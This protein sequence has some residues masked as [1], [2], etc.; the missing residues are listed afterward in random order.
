MRDESGGIVMQS[1]NTQQLRIVDISATVEPPNHTIG[2]DE[3]GTRVKNETM[4]WPIET[5]DSAI[6][7]SIYQILKFKSHLRTHV[8]SPSHM[9]R[10]AKALSDFPASTWLGR[11][12]FF[13]FQVSE[14]T[15]ITRKMLTEADNGRLRKGDIVVAHST[16]KFLP[17]D[18]VN[19]NRPKLSNAAT[20]YLLEKQVKMYGWDNSMGFE[21]DRSSGSDI[22][23][24][25]TLLKNDV[26]L[27]EWICNLEQLVQNV[28]F[29]VAMPG[30]AKVKGVDASPVYAIV[31]EGAD[32]T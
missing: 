17:D 7:P 3:I 16:C 26:P 8:E 12:V 11:M 23:G 31:I 4:I 13:T 21:H 2:P 28:S 22:N 32:F 30:L 25:D 14:N 29:L 5:Y 19:P 15:L 27:L 24:H 10:G 20:E 1:M 18:L 9:F 6:D